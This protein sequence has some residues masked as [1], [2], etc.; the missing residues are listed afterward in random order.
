[1]RCLYQLDAA[2]RSFTKI[3]HR[4]ALIRAD[5]ESSTRRLLNHKTKTH[6]LSIT[7]VSIA[8]PDA[9]EIDNTQQRP[10][11]VYSVS[12]DSVIVKWDFYTGRQ[13]HSQKGNRKPTKKALK[14]SSLKAILKK[15]GH[16]D[17]ILAVD[18]SSDGKYLVIILNHFESMNF[19]CT[20][21]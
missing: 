14:G 16:C 5:G 7:D 11:Y 2:G 9:S 19:G 6:N 10:V 4:Y 13:L 1:M 15:K 3:A 17:Q 12:K 8:I 20:K 21:S 18:V